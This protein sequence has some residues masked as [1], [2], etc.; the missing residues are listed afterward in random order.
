MSSTP[1]HSETHDVDLSHEER[2]IVHSVLVSRAD[3]ALDDRDAPPEWV[4]DLFERIEAGRTTITDQ[5]ARKLSSVLSAYANADGTPTRD[6][7]A[8]ASV[9]ERLETAL[10]C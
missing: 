8:A 7:G 4:V 5:Q 1:Q 3:D 2:W 6:V 9:V 10:E